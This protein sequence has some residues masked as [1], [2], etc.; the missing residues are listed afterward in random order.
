MA[1][2]EVE[3][4]PGDQPATGLLIKAKAEG[5][6]FSGAHRSLSERPASVRESVLSVIWLNC[7][8][9]LLEL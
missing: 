7:Y 3:R 2:F 4:K 1:V 5:D 9:D 8:V 6:Q